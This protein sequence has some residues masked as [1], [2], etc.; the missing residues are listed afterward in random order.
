MTAKSS[1]RIEPKT[2]PE[3]IAAPS[4]DP[5][6]VAKF[7]A[8]AAKWWD[9]AGEFRA[10]HKMNPARIGVVR[11]AL[12]AH[13]RCDVRGPAPLARLKILDIGCGGGLV[14]EPLARLGAAVTG[15]D[16]SQEAIGVAKAHARE[17]GLD[18]HYRAASAEDLSREGAR[19]DA[20]VS[21][22]VVEHVPAPAEFVALAATLLSPGGLL[23]LST[24]NRTMKALAL[25]KLG[26][27][28]VLR[29]A[30]VGAHDFRKFVRPQE[31][32]RALEAAGLARRLLM[33]IV[34]DPLKDDW[35]ASL[36]W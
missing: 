1:Q 9:E 20:V 27:E 21:L 8:L 33:G 15:I 5:A 2:A 3:A 24:I 28:Y 23:V 11:N 19:F 18:I 30:P 26:A 17:Q 14:A 31:L 34:H 29:W 7:A 12:A 22:E 13:F 4:I 10:L 35:R 6:E 36:D 25:A 32:R 16:A